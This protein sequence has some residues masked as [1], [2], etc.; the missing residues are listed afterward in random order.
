MDIQWDG[1]ASLM[2][3]IRFA[4]ADDQEELV[5]R[6]TLRELVGAVLEMAPE[7]HDGLLLRVAGSDWVEEYD[8]D[9]IRELAARPEY[10]GAQGAFD[11]ADLAS[12]DDRAEM[13]AATPIAHGPSGIPAQPPEASERR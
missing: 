9:A 11:T 12:D 5:A 1:S 2:R 3:V 8:A 13:L 6:G 7:A 4:T 10:T